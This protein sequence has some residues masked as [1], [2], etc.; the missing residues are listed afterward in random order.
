M[1]KE[2]LRLEELSCLDPIKDQRLKLNSLSMER[3]SEMLDG[4]VLNGKEIHQL[5]SFKYFAA[6]WR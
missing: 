5:D 4:I 1:D 3:A 2:K 6:V